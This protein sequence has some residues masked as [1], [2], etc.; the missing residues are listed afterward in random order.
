MITKHNTKAHKSNG[1]APTTMDT[2]HPHH[3]RTHPLLWTRKINHGHQHTQD[4]Q[5]T[6]S[7][8]AHDHVIDEEEGTRAAYVLTHIDQSVG[9]NNVRI[10]SAFTHIMLY[11]T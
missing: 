8:H 2:T 3:G 10:K 6:N 7:G 5:R 11:P 1:H 4:T 9:W